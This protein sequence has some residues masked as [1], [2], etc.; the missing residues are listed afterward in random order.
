MITIK[1]NRFL[2]ATKN[3][4]YIF[5]HN[6]AGL[7]IHDYYGKKIDITDFKILE[8]KTGGGFGSAVLYEGRERQYVGQ[9]G[10]GDVFP[11]HW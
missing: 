6:E 8:M 7:L 11:G 9:F 10:F 3:T 1:D 5:R 4:I 2:L